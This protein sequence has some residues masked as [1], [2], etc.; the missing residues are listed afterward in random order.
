MTPNIPFDVLFLFS[1]LR[2][3]GGGKNLDEIIIA[4]IYY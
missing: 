2:W 1:F 3:R 4:L